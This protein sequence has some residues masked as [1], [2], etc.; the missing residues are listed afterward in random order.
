MLSLALDHGG[1]AGR[2]LLCFAALGQL[3]PGQHAACADRAADQRAAKAQGDHAPADDVGG[4]A[5]FLLL[6][7]LGGLGHMVCTRLGLLAPCSGAGRRGGGM[8]EG[9]VLGGVMDFFRREAV[10]VKALR[11]GLRLD[12]RHGI[13][14][15]EAL[16]GLRHII[17]RDFVFGEVSLVQGLFGFD[18]G[19]LCFLRL[20]GAGLVPFVKFHI[21]TLLCIT[22]CVPFD[23]FILMR[24]FEHKLAKKQTVCEQFFTFL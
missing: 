6:D 23:A 7:G 2:L 14:R 18:P 13:K 8:A 9:L 22:V 1:N 10:V 5:L 3:L 17:R 4:L 21:Q 16:R 24:I 15:V 12:V 20:L 19:V 11:V